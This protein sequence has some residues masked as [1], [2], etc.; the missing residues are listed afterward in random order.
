[1]SSDNSEE[2][3]EREAEAWDEE[4]LIENNKMADV[5][6]NLSVITTNVN[7]WNTDIY[8]MEVC[9]MNKN[10]TKQNAQSHY[11]L[12]LRHSFHVQRQHT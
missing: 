1:M 3:K 2:G 11:K 12:F 5:S 9:R 10:K 6:A 7:G 8:K 4:K